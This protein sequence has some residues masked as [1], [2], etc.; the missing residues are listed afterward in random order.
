MN[1]W[2]PVG[3]GQLGALGKSC[4]HCCKMDNQQGPIA[5]H[6]NSAQCHGQPGWEQ[7]GE[8]GFVCM[9]G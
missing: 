5:E 2:L 7:D 9:Y 6:M 3:K 4:T 8:N 1:L